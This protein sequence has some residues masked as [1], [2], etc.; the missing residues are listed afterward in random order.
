MVDRLTHR[1]PMN[2]SQL[3]EALGITKQAVSKLKA[4]GMP[5]HSLKA[6]QA[7]RA[8]NLDASRSEAMLRSA[9]REPLAEALRRRM[10][11]EAGLA[12]LRRDREAASLIGVKAMQH[13]L[14]ADYQ[15]L[16]AGADALVKALAPR[17]ASMTNP[18]EIHVELDIA[19]REFLQR[20]CAR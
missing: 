10:V 1:K 3:A 19:I 4:R 13:A 8:A 14:R 5:V 20:E 18:A 9:S 11:A 12:E 16:S 7:W 15:H 6:A 2:Q 17:L